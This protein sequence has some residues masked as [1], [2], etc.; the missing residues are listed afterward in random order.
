MALDVIDLRQFYASPLGR[1]AQEAI[2]AAVAARWSPVSGLAV[3]GLG[4][5]PPYLEPIRDEAERAIALMP[6]RLGVLAWPEGALSATGL[7]D[8]L[9]LPLRDAVIDRLLV[10]HALEI[11]EDAHAL[12]EELWRVLTP[13]GHMI[14]VA[15][16]RRGGWARRDSTPFGYGQPYSRTQIT[17]LLRQ[18]LFTPVHWQEALYFPPSRSSLMV[19]LAPTLERLGTF[20]KLPFAGVHIVEATKQ[21]YRPVIAGRRARAGARLEPVLVP[22]ARQAE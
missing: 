14:L 6:G 21:L 1:I 7:V 18:A 4:Y 17:A 9:E 15:P 11:S 3:L 8:P 10:V 16:N 13:G 12:L 22:S 5:A 19:S 2:A 20:L